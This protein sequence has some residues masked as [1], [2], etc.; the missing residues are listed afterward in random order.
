[1]A[2]PLHLWLT[3][4]DGSDIRGSSAVSGREG[5]I[6]VL[7]LTHGVYTPACGV[8]GG[9]MGGRL[10]RPLTIEKEIDRTSPILYGQ[11]RAGRSDYIRKGRCTKATGVQRLRLI[12]SSTDCDDLFVC[13]V[14]TFLFPAAPLGHTER[15]KCDE[16]RG[17]DSVVSSVRWRVVLRSPS[18]CALPPDTLVRDAAMARKIDSMGALDRDSRR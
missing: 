8:T 18:P 2:I 1:M 13:M 9:L 7:S 15:W 5:N 10:H 17:A 6:E 14:R 4:Q 12:W 16:A 11:W 3:D